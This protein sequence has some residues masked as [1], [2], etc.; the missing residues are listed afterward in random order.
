DVTIPV[1][2]GLIYSSGPTIWS[3]ATALTTD[4]LNEILGMKEG[5]VANGLKFDKGIMAIVKAYCRK[6]YLD[7]RVRPTPEFDDGAKKVTY[8][9]EVSEGPQYRMGSLLF[10]GLAERDAKALRSSWTLRRG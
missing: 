5:N 3:G 4:R 6:G 7:A 1:A 9:I 8:K 10:K 2:E